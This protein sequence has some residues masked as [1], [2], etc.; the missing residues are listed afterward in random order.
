MKVVKNEKEI[1]IFQ[2]FFCKPI[3]WLVKEKD[4]K[5][6]GGL[7]SSGNKFSHAIGPILL[8]YFLWLLKARKHKVVR[9]NKLNKANT[10]LMIQD[11]MQRGMGRKSNAM[12]KEKKE[13]RKGIT[14]IEKS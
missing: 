7:E 4:R 10:V 14:T 11:E 2:T 9:E 12:Q 6:L 1:K 5:T 8:A 13:R 3:A